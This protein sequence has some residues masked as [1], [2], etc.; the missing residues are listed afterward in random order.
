MS[1]LEIIKEE[2]GESPILLLDDF[3]SELDSKRRKNLLSNI[4]DTQVIITCTDEME[5][6]F[7]GNIYKVKEGK[8]IK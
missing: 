7:L 6:N 5:N 4:G 3:M 8:V 2:T 1:E